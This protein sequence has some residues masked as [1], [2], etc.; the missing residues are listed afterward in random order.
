MGMRKVPMLLL[1]ALA[2]AALLRAEGAPSG[3]AIVAT[4]QAAVRGSGPE[5]L[6]R[7][8]DEAINRAQSRAIEM[9]VGTIIDSETMVENFQLL[10]DKIISQVKGYITGYEIVKDNKGE[11]G[12]YSVTIEATVALARLEK[13]VRALN[14]IKEKK[15][16]PRIMVIMREFGEDVFGDDSER[17]GGITQTAME[18]EFL[19]LDFPLVDSEQ[20]GIIDERDQA[21][22]GGDEARAAALGK[23]YGAD[24]IIV[25]EASSGFM[26]AS[27]PHGVS[28]YHFDA[29]GSAKVIKV[30]TARIIAR[31]SVTSGRVVRGGRRTAARDALAIVGEKLARKIREQLIENWR[32]EAFNTVTVQIVATDADNSRRRALEKDLAAIRGVREVSERS[33]V[34]NTLVLDCKID[35]AIWKDFEEMLGTLPSVK[36]EPTAKTQNRI[37]VRLSARAAAPPAP[38]GVIPE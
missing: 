24:V 28:V 33:W 5:A 36:A 25:G 6:T 19:K 27:R 29:Q 16:N 12:I 15:N 20:M 13:D 38:K 4:G 1:C 7:A 3:R 37:D 10:E 18:K 14:I 26:D 11:T 32:G 8:R 35:G 22:A 23:R 17:A 34:N 2:F 31:E 9:G 30:D 21:L